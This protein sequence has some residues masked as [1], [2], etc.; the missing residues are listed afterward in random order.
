MEGGQGDAAGHGGVLLGRA[1]VEVVDEVPELGDPCGG[2]LGGLVDQGLQRLPAV[3]GL[4]PGGRR[5][6]VQPITEARRA[7]RWAGLPRPGAAAGGTAQPG[8]GLPDLG[9]VEEA[10]R[11]ADDVGDAARRE[12]LL[13]GLGLGVDAE[14]HGDLARRRTASGPSTAAATASASATSSGY[15]S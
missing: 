15:G 9:A 5:L 11:A 3:S 2:L 6:G 13:V 10:G 7:R 4:A 1:A 12:R 8:H 14:Q